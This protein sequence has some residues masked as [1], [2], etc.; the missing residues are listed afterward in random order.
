MILVAEDNEVNQM[1]VMHTLMNAG[2]DFEIV[3][4][5]K[6]AVEVFQQRSPDLIL[7]DISMPVMSGYEATLAIREMEKGTDGHVIIIGVTANALQGDREACLE[8]GMDDYISKPLKL[9][10]LIEMIAGWLDSEL[11][12]KKLT[13]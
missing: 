4:D 9:D 1:V 13:A 10:D 6:Q 3:A 7:M 2:Y 8:A 5:G 11:R 12:A